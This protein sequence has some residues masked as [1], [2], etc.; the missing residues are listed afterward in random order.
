MLIIRF[1]GGNFCISFEQFCLMMEF[2]KEQKKCF[3]EVDADNSGSVDLNELTHAFLAS[4]IPLPPQTVQQIGLRY[5]QDNSGSI[6]F[7]EFLQMMIEWTQVA[8]FQ[9]HFSTF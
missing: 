4:G 2:L 1:G 7:D 3:L 8:S 6:E 5:D 9:N